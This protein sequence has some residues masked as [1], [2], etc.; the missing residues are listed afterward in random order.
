MPAD[1][2]Q[3]VHRLGRTAR[4]GKGGSGLLLLMESEQ[5]FLKEVRRFVPEQCAYG[6]CSALG[7]SILH[8]AGDVSYS[9]F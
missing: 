6:P 3:Y 7:I 4:A 5:V 1:A 8:P 9:L 2:A